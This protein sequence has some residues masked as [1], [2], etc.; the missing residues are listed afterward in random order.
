MTSQ[1]F[2]IQQHVMHLI[3][4]IQCEDIRRKRELRENNRQNIT[5][6]VTIKLSDG[7]ETDAVTRDLSSLG[8]GLLSSTRL[9]TN[10]VCELELELDSGTNCVVA[11]C[12]WCKPFGKGFFLSGWTFQNLN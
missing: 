3:S 7:K 9:E 11:K 2:S 6:P 10:L 8:I 5:V 4:Q 12:I 1:V